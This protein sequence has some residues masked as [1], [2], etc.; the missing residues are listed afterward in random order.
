M[1]TQLERLEHL[2]E[3]GGTFEQFCA[4]IAELFRVK[5]HEVAVLSLRN[6]MLSFVHPKELRNIGSIPLSSTAHASRSAVHKKFELSNNFIKVRHKSVFEAVKMGEEFDS[7]TIQ[8]IISGPILSPSKEVV[9][10]IQISRKGSSPERSGPDFT[11]EDLNHLKN[12]SELLGKAFPQLQDA[13][14]PQN[15]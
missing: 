7:L 12:V 5:K 13:P 11:Q 1:G 8:K 2:A 6:H 14:E 10:V 15:P 3:V 4:A 9:G